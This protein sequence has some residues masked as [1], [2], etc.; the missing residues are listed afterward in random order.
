MTAPTGTS[1]RTEAARASR[2][3]ACIPVRSLGDGVPLRTRYLRDGRRVHPRQFVT[4]ALHPD[5]ISLLEVSLPQLQGDAVLQLALDAPLERPRPVDRIV[6]LLRQQLARFG[7]HL[8]F[9]IPRR[10]QLFQ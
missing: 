7:H 2:S 3:A 5:G 4:V 9:E 10:E 1:S 8:E 6:A